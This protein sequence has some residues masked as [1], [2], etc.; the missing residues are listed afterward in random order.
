MKFV[1]CMTRNVLSVTSGIKNAKTKIDFTSWGQ[2]GVVIHRQRLMLFIHVL[3]V[4]LDV[5][6]N[7]RICREMHRRKND[8]KVLPNSGVSKSSFS[9]ADIFSSVYQKLVKAHFPLFILK[10][11]LCFQRLTSVDC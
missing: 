4:V 10:I 1:D 8:K 2:D 5:R 6:S 7:K 11:I 9:S 3:R